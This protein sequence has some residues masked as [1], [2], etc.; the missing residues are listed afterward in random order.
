[1]MFLEEN[2][3]HHNHKVVE[4]VIVHCCSLPCIACFLIGPFHYIACVWLFRPINF[5]FFHTVFTCFHGKYPKASVILHENFF[6][7]K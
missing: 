6:A 7:Q 2:Q 5:C 1:M 3:L 4:R